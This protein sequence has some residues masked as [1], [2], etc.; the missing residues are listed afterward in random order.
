MSA[1][2]GERL[3]RIGRRRRELAVGLLLEEQRPVGQHARLVQGFAELRRYGAEVLA[4]HHA[5]PAAALLREDRE[6]IVE[7]V[8]HVSAL[9]WLCAPRNPPQAHERHDVV[10]AQ[11]PALR[12]VGAQELDE[13]RVRAL[14]QSAR[15]VRRQAPVLALRIEFVGRRA[16]ARVEGERGLVAPDFGAAGVGAEREVHVKTD[17]HAELARARLRGVELH[18]RLHLKVQMET[19]PLPI[20]PRK[21]IDCRGA[22][23]AILLRPAPPVAA[24]LLAQRFEQGVG[25]YAFRA[26]AREFLRTF[27]VFKMLEEQFQ[28][29]ELRARD[30]LVVHELRFAQRAQPLLESTRLHEAP[31]GRAPWIFCNPFYIEI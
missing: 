17:R 19:D 2:A 24:K 21:S 20:F 14:A 29:F 27:S 5:A 10:H 28:N 26:F 30:A 16:A 23:I 11:R 12:H 25:A 13:R 4:D 15:V 6:K 22:R 8:M 7:R 18:S 3:A 1:Y 9:V 31:R